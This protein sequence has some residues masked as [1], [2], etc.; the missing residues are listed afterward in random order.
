MVGMDLYQPNYL[1]IFPVNCL[2]GCVFD[3]LDYS[4]MKIDSQIVIILTCNSLS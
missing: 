4:H 1:E 2:I 3:D